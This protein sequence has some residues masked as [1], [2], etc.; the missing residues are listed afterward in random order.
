MHWPAKSAA[1]V[2]AGALKW[3]RSPA[4]AMQAPHGRIHLTAGTIDLI[5]PF[6][7]P[8][9]AA[10]PC[11]SSFCWQRNQAWPTAQRQFFAVQA[12]N[13]NCPRNKRTI[14]DDMVR[15][16]L[17][18]QAN[19]LSTNCRPEK[20]LMRDFLRSELADMINLGITNFHSC[21][22]SK[23]LSMHASFKLSIGCCPAKTL[24]FAGQLAG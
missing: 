7:P 1:K 8:A 5:S 22:L 6:T 9:K 11:H 12:K 21:H 3:R 24:A 16:M 20:P 19:L 10:G 14:K 2:A 17:G 23:S 4:I 18:N 15:P 13:D